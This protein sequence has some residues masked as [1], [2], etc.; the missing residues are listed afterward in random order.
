MKKILKLSGLVGVLLF[1]LSG[2]GA[3]L[4]YNVQNAPIQLKQ[5]TS[6]DKVYKA[7]K[8]A[9]HMR[10]WRVSKVSP[11]VAKAFI[12]VRGKHQA[13]VLIT[14]NKSEYSIEYQDSA[15]LKFNAENNTIH[16][17]YNS[18]VKNLDRDIQF[19]ISSLMD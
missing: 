5:G 14:Y 18:W 4:V 13:T 9:G 10:G 17:N 12:D 1:V 16:K 15:N 3:A 7:I 6:V 2:C 19:A 8:Q 11:G